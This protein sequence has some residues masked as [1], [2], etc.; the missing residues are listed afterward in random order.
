MNDDEPVPVQIE[1][2]RVE[3]GAVVRTW[4][5][6]PVEPNASTRSAGTARPGAGLK[7]S[8]G[9]Y[10]FRVTAQNSDGALAR[11]SATTDATRDA[12][13]FYGHIFPIRGRHDYGQRVARSAPAA[14]AT[15]IRGRT[16]SPGAAPSWSPPAPGA[17]KFNQ[18]HSAAG[19]Y[20]VVDGYKSKYDYVYMHL[21]ERSPF[22]RGRP[23]D[24]RAR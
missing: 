2:V 14:R 13:D 15:R 11:S 6:G 16:S 21:Q 12:F 24:R 17:V 8:A 22:Q 20:I 5:P 10:V 18:Y 9:R 3:D 19:Y 1:L 23:G 4:N 7:A